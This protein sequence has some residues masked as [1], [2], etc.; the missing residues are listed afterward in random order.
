MSRYHAVLVIVALSVAAVAPGTC[1][2]E[3]DLAARIELFTQMH[4]TYDP[5]SESLK[6]PLAARHEALEAL[7]EAVAEGRVNAVTSEELGA[8]WTQVG[9]Y[10]LLGE[11]DS[12]TQI[13]LYTGRVSALAVD[14]NDASGHTV[15]LGGANGGV[16]RTTDGGQ[17]WENVVSTLDHT[18]RGSLAIGSLAVV[19]YGNPPGEKAYV[20]AGTGEAVVHCEGYYGDGIWKYDPDADE[21]A[22]EWRIVG[23]DQFYAMAVADIV[24]HP[25]HANVLWAATTFAAHGRLDGSCQS[26]VDYP[27]PN[28][29]WSYGIFMSND[30]GETWEQVW[31]PDPGDPGGN[32]PVTVV[33][34]GVSDLVY[35]GFDESLGADCLLAGVA[36]LRPDGSG[37]AR[38]IWE[39]CFTGAG[40]GDPMVLA[41]ATRKYD[42]PTTA[43]A[44]T[45][46][47]MATDGSGLSAV[48]YAIAAKDIGGSYF[49][50]LLRS[51]DGGESWV[52]LNPPAPPDQPEDITCQHSNLDPQDYGEIRNACERVQRALA[53]MTSSASAPTTS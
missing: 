51:G 18:Y 33:D 16:W 21:G 11:S 29:G 12:G 42:F 53:R 44:V 47:E 2:G 6:V 38:G 50:E 13:G 41:D 43:E 9:R 26:P 49:A 7:R 28:P 35:L 40:H 20:F 4:G 30:F 3:E 34:D 46:V 48:V 23:S 1:C 52:V 37:P 24:G 39:V 15:Y 10:P 45:R 36:D 17:S 19:P 31:D 5:K 8:L 27:N 22:G 32:P 25:V 14:P